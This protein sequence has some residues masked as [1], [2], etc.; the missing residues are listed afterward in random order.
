MQITK[1][2]RD[3]KMLGHAEAFRFFTQARIIEANIDK[4]YLL[5]AAHPLSK[6]PKPLKKGIGIP[7]VIQVPSM[8]N[9]KY[10]TP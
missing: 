7:L 2:P 6:K 3:F 4:L 1:G 9:S 8:A 5:S 10:S